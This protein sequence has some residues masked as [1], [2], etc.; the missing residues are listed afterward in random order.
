MTALAVWSSI[1]TTVAAVEQRR[2]SLR[3]A[4]ERTKIRVALVKSIAYQD[5]YT[6]NREKEP[7]ALLRSSLQ[8]I[9]PLGLFKILSGMFFLVRVPKEAETHIFEEKYEAL[10]EKDRRHYFGLMDQQRSNSIDVDEIDFGEF[11][12]VIAL[13]TCVPS[14]IVAAHPKVLWATMVEDHNRQHY[15]LYNRRCPD[16]YDIFLNLMSGPSLRSLV[17]RRHSIDWSYSFTGSNVLSEIYPDLGKTDIIHVEDHQDMRRIRK[18]GKDSKWMFFTE[19]A[20]NAE[21]YARSLVRSRV[22][23]AP[24]PNRPLGGLA[25]IDA[26]SAGAVVVANRRSMW[27]PYVVTKNCDCNNMADGIKI[28]RR[29]ME[30]E[31]LLRNEREKQDA[32]LDWFVLSRPWWQIMDFLTEGKKK[33]KVTEK[34]M[35]LP[36]VSDFIGERCHEEDLKS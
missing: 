22:F 27:N 34:L 23:F 36:A 12:V 13:E 3:D 6:I 35:A 17:R 15:H 4:L 7:Q 2:R 20:Q 10:N 24:E 16:G 21:A 18:I 32:R 30:S 28:V 31:E 14:R 9:G 11:D 5:L 19:G 29:L 26:A 8:R 1:S 33:K 25:A